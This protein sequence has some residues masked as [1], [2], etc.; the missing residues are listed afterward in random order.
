[1]PRVDA[2][3]LDFAVPPEG[4]QGGSETRAGLRTPHSTRVRHPVSKQGVGLL[5]SLG[6]GQPCRRAFPLTGKHVHAC[7]CVQAMKSCFT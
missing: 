2:A 1:M 6:A 4:R 7:V 3:V 5:G